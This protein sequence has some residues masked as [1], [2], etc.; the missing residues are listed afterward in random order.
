PGHMMAAILAYPELGRPAGLPLP[1]GSMREH[2]WWPARNDLLWPHETA[3]EFL[4][5]VLVRIAQLFPGDLVHVGGDECAYL[6]WESDPQMERILRELGVE[7]TSQLQAWFMER[8]RQTL[9]A[10]GK[11]I[12]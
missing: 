1:G 4:D 12:V 10:H 5:A 9:A 3:L 11:R 2:M 6:Q 8:A 7:D